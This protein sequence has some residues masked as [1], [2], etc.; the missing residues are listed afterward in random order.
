MGQHGPQV[1]ILDVYLTLEARRMKKT[2]ES[3]EDV[4][5]YCEVWYFFLKLFVIH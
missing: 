3:L 2:V 1:S 4:D 5:I